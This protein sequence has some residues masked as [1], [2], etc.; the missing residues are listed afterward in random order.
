MQAGTS[1]CFGST[2]SVQTSFS[3]RPVTIATPALLLT[4]CAS[5]R[6]PAAV[7][8]GEGP[9]ATS[10]WCSSA[11][12]CAASASPSVCLSFRQTGHR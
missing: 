6:R 3:C 12:S 8:A 4:C 5:S 11:S 10:S 2:C 1:R 7:V 9:P